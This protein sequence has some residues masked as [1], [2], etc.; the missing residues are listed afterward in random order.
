M[1]ANISKS[2]A[3]LNV[4]AS[5]RSF[6]GP[7]AKLT[8]VTVNS[9]EYVKFTAETPSNVG[10]VLDG[11]A[12]NAG[13]GLRVKRVVAD[14]FRTIVAGGVKDAAGHKTSL[15]KTV[16]KAMADGIK[17]GTTDTASPP[18]PPHPNS[19]STHTL[20]FAAFP[21]VPAAALANIEPS[22]APTPAELSSRSSTS[23]CSAL[24]PNPPPTTRHNCTM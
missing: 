8:S 1:S 13:I 9:H 6:G 23:S 17:V 22:L 14:N 11:A 20:F 24:W 18:H 3:N 5:V 4:K 2:L 15:G 19:C 16:A 7:T 12:F 21:E 10:S